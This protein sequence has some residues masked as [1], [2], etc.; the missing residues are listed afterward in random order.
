MEPILRPAAPWGRSARVNA[1]TNRPAQTGRRGWVRSWS[2]R[3]ISLATSLLPPWPAE[4]TITD[5]DV[6]RGYVEVPTGSRLRITSNNPAGYFIDFFT[7]LPI[8]RSVRVSNSNGSA[9]LGPDGGT[10]IE[11]GQHGRNLPLDLSYRFMLAS[12]A[13]PGTY[14]WPLAL[15]VRPL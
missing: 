12:N 7:R 14:A 11:R 15:N 3:G 10:I 6:L 4:I 8:F 9:D 1:P 2:R 5:G 13:T